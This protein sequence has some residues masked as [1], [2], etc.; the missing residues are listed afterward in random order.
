MQDIHTIE[1]QSVDQLFEKFTLEAIFKKE[2]TKTTST[3]DVT[4][5]LTTMFYGSVV[6]AH[7]NQ[8]TNLKFF[9]RRNVDLF[10]KGLQ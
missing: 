4:N 3:R 9:F 5:M 6:T 2:I 1:I 7:I 10:L 8:Q